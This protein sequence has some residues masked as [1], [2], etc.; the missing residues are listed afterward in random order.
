[1]S[2][3]ERLKEERERLRLTQPQ[4]A[5]ITGTSKQTQ[6]AYENGR[7]PPKTKFLAKLAT[8]GFD[9]SYVIT[10][11]RLENTASTPMEL[12]FLRNCRAFK[13]NA[14]RQMALNALVA[15]SGYTPKGDDE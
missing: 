10:G 7:T 11:E 13:D 9:V 6:S 4:I 5:E 1:M 8:F 14:S 3:G 2:V 12:A 15:M